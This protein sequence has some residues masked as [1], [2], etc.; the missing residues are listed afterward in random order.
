MK[1][2]CT[3]P[4][5]YRGSR[6]GITGLWLAG[7]VRDVSAENGDYLL[8]TFPH[9]FTLVDASAARP[10]AD[11]AMRSPTAGRSAPDLSRLLK[12]RD[13]TLVKRITTGACDDLLG[14]LSRQVP[15]DRS[16]VRAAIQERTAALSGG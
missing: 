6:P 7:S 15:A 5:G 16:K 14:H 4:L 10:P 13:R 12:L 1:V 2:R 8:R 9:R 11:R 3:D